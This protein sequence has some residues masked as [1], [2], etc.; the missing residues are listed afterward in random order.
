MESDLKFITNEKTAFN[1]FI[2][3]YNTEI[4]NLHIL[5]DSQNANQQDLMDEVS[6][7]HETKN[8]LSEDYIQ[9]LYDSN[10]KVHS[11]NDIL[12]T[13]GSHTDQKKQ[14]N[15]LYVA[16]SVFQLEDITH[17]ITEASHLLMES[18]DNTNNTIHELIDK[19][20]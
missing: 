11:K 3:V 2:Q 14:I 18:G 10:P 20:K 19:S 1:G 13:M 12:G 9:K 6:R 4:Q 7:L 8:L 15:D 16:E 5:L 17:Q